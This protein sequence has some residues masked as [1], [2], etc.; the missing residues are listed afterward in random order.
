MNGSKIS[1]VA[2][3]GTIACEQDATGALVPRRTAEQL[4]EAAGVEVPVI[5]VNARAL[6]S[7]SMTLA[8][9]DDL[10]AT[11]R[12]QLEDPEVAGVVVTHGTDSMVDTA[13]A[14]DLF[15]SD[16]R[17]VVFT[18]AQRSADAEDPDGPGNLRAAID[19]AARG[20]DPGHGVVVAFGG[21]IHP[22]RGLVK[23][24][25]HALDA[26]RP[27]YAGTFN[28]LQR[29][30]PIAPVLLA[31]VRIPIVSAWAGAAPDLINAV[32]DMRPDGIVVEGMGSGNV[33][34]QMGQA[35]ERALHAEIPVVV[36]TVVPRGKVEFAYGGA[37]GGST[38]GQAGA[39]PG[40]WLR[41]SQARIALA[42]AV[43]AG[44]DPGELIGD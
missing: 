33:S 30:A 18:G 11:V 17:P 23:S 13:F 34:E 36:T 24:D 7:S 4:V 31:G 14:L 26:F 22:A 29:P 40:G 2:T 41:A 20:G 3:G 1:V 19:Y 25:T 32:I 27:T 37:G 10:A 39:L 15:H 6:D 28:G 42:A 35:I 5:A 38:L 12:A 9:I 8:D 43:S 16:S 21:H 44:I